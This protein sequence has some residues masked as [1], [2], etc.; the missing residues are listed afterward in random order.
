[1]PPAEELLA[2]RRRGRSPEPTR[3]RWWIAAAAAAGAAASVLIAVGVVALTRGD[4]LVA[5]SLAP[6]TEATTS[7]TTA[8]PS[9]LRF[10]LATQTPA[11]DTGEPEAWDWPFLSPG[12]I[13]FQDGVYHMLRNGFGDEKPT[14][15]G[16]GIS[17]NGVLWGAV[18]AEPVFTLDGGQVHTGLVTSDGTWVVYF[19]SIMAKDDAG[20]H[21]TIGRASAP[22]PEGPWTV[23]A[24]PVLEPGGSGDW[25]QSAVRQPA[26]VATQGGFV[27]L[28]VGAGEKGSAIGR[29]TSSNGI[30]WIKDEQPVL[31]PE[32]EWEGS[33]LT[34]PD[35]VVNEEGLVLMYGNRSG[36]NR[37]IATSRDGVVWTRFPGN[38]VLTTEAVPRATMKTGE[39]HYRDGVYLLYLENG[40][41]L[42][43]T[44]IAVLTRDEP[45]V[46]R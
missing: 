35:V 12:V 4:D 45:I 11:F 41:S 34:R 2:G 42:S 14:G 40:G 31:V 36:S 6:T 16:Y 26:V 10:E 8:A 39:L 43:G 46:I 17:D 29:A 15:I 37:G 19:D 24:T 44:N 25:D 32:A 20:Q 18:G 33:E 7:P 38:P 27:M 13:V 3:P 22:G 23:D 9:I 1:V 30:A 28:Y 5:E 21:V